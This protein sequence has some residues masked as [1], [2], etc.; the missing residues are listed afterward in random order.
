MHYV[1]TERI[2]GIKRHWYDNLWTWKYDVKK[3]WNIDAEDVD[4]VVLQIEN[5]MMS[6]IQHLISE[7]TK[8]DF[9]D[10]YS[11][12]K[13]Y[14]KLRQEFGAILGIDHSKLIAISHYYAH[15]LS[16]HT[17]TDKTP[18]I[19]M[20]IDCYGDGDRS[21]S[22][23]RDDKLVDKGIFCDNSL[24]EEINNM[25]RRLK[26]QAHHDVEIAG[27]VMGLQSYGRINKIGRAH[28]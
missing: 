19:Y 21:W 5:G 25:G 14:I 16:V 17:M 24:G 20:V 27:K 4:Y 18:D 26:V 13:N 8:E 15:A 2:T 23:Y 7:E 3:L 28:V 12:N 9:N 1:K 6:K 10:L 22:V 11:G